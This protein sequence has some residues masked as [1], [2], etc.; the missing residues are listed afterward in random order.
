MLG[1]GKRGGR[2]C[3]VFMATRHGVRRIGRVRVRAARGT[4]TS[5]IA[6]ATLMYVRSAAGMQDTAGRVRLPVGR[7]ALR[8]S[9]DATEL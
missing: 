3:A 2:P 8:S 1:R 6:I 5:H 7:D 4:Q 9:A